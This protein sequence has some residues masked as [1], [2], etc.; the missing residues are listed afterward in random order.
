MNYAGDEVSGEKQDNDLN[1]V[2]FEGS[3]FEHDVI[4]YVE[5]FRMY[6][7]EYGVTEQEVVK[8]PVSLPDTMAKRIGVLEKGQK[9]R[10]VGRI[11]RMDDGLGLRAEHLELVN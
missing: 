9:V 5:S 4:L 1:S 6:R 3:V 8:V 2:I 7:G 10:I 11:A